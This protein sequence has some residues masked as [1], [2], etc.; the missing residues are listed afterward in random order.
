M[1]LAGSC[2]RWP[3]IT[4]MKCTADVADEKLQVSIAQPLVILAKI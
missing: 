3:R 4:G 1:W 2:S